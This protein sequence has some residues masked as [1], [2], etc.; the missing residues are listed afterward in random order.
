V[1]V[2]R[3]LVA[4]SLLALSAASAPAGEPTVYKVGIP[5]SAFRDL[6]PGLVSFAGEPFKALMKSQTGLDGEVALGSDAMRIAKELDDGKLQLG[7]FFGHEF[8]WAKEKYPALEP[9]VCTVPR[10]REVQA[11]LIVR[12]DCKATSL[13]DLKGAKLVVAK[14]GRD[15]AR[16]FLERQKAEHLPYGGSCSTEKADTVHDALYK[17]IESDADVT[18]ADGAS[19]SYFQKL[20]PGPSQNLKVLARSEVFPPTV[21]AYKKGAI[22]DAVVAKIRDGLL[23]AHESSKGEKLMN[24]I[25]LDRFEE[26][27][28]GYDDMLQKC[29]K[30]YPAPSMEK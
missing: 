18:V 20:Y 4:I 17:I 19:W 22:D 8:A 7:V 23:T 6:P 25:K 9:L 24:L 12:W 27:P 1:L 16:L 14:N 30:L 13:A 29:R 15:H 3:F 5:K 10:P 21:V 26:V 28:V 2:N 11:L